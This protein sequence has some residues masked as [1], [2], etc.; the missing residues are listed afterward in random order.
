MA[1][2][3]ESRRPYQIK[4]TIMYLII[5]PPCLMEDEGRTEFCGS[6]ATLEEATEAV[7]RL[8]DNDKGYFKRSNFRIVKYE[9]Y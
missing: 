4:G 1:Y 3:F 6:Y 8:S 9:N 5:R 7:N 2:G